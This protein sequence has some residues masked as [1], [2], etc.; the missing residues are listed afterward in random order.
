MANFKK[1]EGMTVRTVILVFLLSL[2]AS[3]PAIPQKIGFFLEGKAKR[4]VIPFKTYNNLIVLTLFVNGKV[5]MKFILDSGVRS[6]I[7]FDKNVTDVLGVHYQRKIRIRGVGEIEEIVAYIATGL[8]FRYRSLR[9]IGI[10]VLVLGEDYLKLRNYLGTD[11]HGIIGYDFFK[12]FIVSINY[13][14]GL[15]TLTKPEYYKK[16][17]KYQAIPLEIINTK[18]FVN[19]PLFINDTTEIKANLMIDTGAS[20]ALVLHADSIGLLQLPPR[21]IKMVLGRGLSGEI[22]GSI[23]YIKGCMLGNYEVDNVLASFPE[24]TSYPDSLFTSGREGAIGG[25][26]LGKFHLVFDY[27]GEHKLYLKKNK[28]FSKPFTYNMSGL[29]IIVVGKNLD[30][31]RIS[32][33]RKGSPADLAGLREGDFIE[34]MNSMTAHNYVRKSYVFEQKDSYSHQ[35]EFTNGEKMELARIYKLLS[36]HEGRWINIVVNRNGIKIRYKFRL[37]K[38]I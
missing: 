32:S 19:T 27:Y 6:I 23:A 38:E 30:Q 1:A 10:S 9:G 11:I 7:F 2:M 26:I 28:F 14:S 18:P 16:R 8:N 17:K 25:E 12:R 4:E 35:V 13:E 5:P 24:K 15:L 21:N 29:E 22:N 20:H 37:K 3:I 36:S 33:V 31:F 34:E